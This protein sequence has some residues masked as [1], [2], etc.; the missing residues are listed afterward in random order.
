[1]SPACGLLRQ[2]PDTQRSKKQKARRKIRRAVVESEEVR[3]V[4]WNG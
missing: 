4:Y 1:M 3:A 2:G